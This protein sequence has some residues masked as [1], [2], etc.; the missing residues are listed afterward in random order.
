MR[1][2]QLSV[3]VVIITC[4]TLAYAGT[5]TERKEKPEIGPQ[6]LTQ[7]MTIDSAPSRL[8]DKNCEG[9]LLARRGCCSHH[10]GVCGCDES[11]DRIECCDGTLSPSCTCSGY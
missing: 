11:V 7:I 4:F 5:P 10:G 3:I 8:E 9:L 2:I 1:K 6:N